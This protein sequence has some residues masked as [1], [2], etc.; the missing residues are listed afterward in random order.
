MK[1]AP[2]YQPSTAKNVSVPKPFTGP[3][4]RFRALLDPAAGSAV[5]E[6]RA[7]KVEH[8]LDPLLRTTSR[9]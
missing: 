3:A 9:N 5:L 6:Q 7:R 4:S 2:S 8:L 1:P